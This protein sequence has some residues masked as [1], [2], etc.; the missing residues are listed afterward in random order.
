[1]QWVL[2]VDSSEKKLLLM[3]AWWEMPMKKVL[4]E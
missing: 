2:K 4:R 3:K 1:M